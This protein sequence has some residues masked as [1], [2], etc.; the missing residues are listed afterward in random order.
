MG[1]TWLTLFCIC[2]MHGVCMV[3]SGRRFINCLWP[4]HLHQWIICCILSTNNQQKFKSQRVK[5]LFT[6]IKTTN[7]D[8]MVLVF[9]FVPTSLMWPQTFRSHHFSVRI[10]YNFF[11]HLHKRKFFDIF[12]STTA[13][14][15]TAVR[16]ELSHIS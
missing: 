10:K 16:N 14:A 8:D 9:F 1:R 4:S 5:L 7:D 11:S 3:F 15:A 13:A 6:H 12:I 2:I